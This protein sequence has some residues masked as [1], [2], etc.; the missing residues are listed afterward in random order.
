M[1]LRPLRMVIAALVALALLATG[2]AS[3]DTTSSSGGTGAGSGTET[4]I[5]AGWVNATELEP[6]TGG[7]LEVTLP[8]RPGGLDPNTSTLGLV[9]QGPI[10]TAI[11]DSLMRYDAETGTFTGQ[12]AEGLTSNDELTEWTLKLRPDVTFSD[13]T[14]FNAAA[15]VASMERLKTAR[16]LAATYPSFFSSIEA[17]DDL[18]VVLRLD[19]PLNNV[20]ALLATEMGFIVSP[21][22]VAAAGE[23]FSRSPVGAGPF[24]V[25]RFDPAAEL[26]LV[27]N[28]AYSLGEV[29]LDRIR[30]TWSNDQGANVDK[31][32]VG[33]A[34]MAFVGAVPQV[35]RA[36]SEGLPT[37]TTLVGGNG[38]AINNAAGKA[39]PG[40]D[41]RVRKAISMAIDPQVSNERAFD[42]DGVMGRWMMPPGNR[43]HVDTP[44]SVGDQDEAR[45]LVDAVKAETGWDG[46]AR[47][48]AQPSDQDMALSYQAQLNAIGFDAQLDPVQDASQM[49][50]RVTANR[51]FD[52]SIWI[53]TMYDTNIWQALS[54]S[55]SSTSTANYSGFSSP[56]MDALLDEL[57]G[58]P[59]DE[60]TRGV[61]DEIAEL[62]QAEQ[63]FFFAGT[64]TFST[65][66][67]DRVGG[68]VPT[69]QGV[70]LWSDVFKA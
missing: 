25:E 41:P 54:R 9:T 18:T 36:I 62:W 44:F 45:R 66:T 15:V 21:T 29:R 48:I 1:T 59:D 7:T 27:K 50:E 47:I 60:A 65:V 10:L 11:F 55:L 42:G 58:A 23:G 52:L 31:V 4:P 3:D 38:M 22:A 2:C 64:Q 5:R 13:G 28:P 61:L 57:R 30:M 8:A 46:K 6:S 14:P 56:E 26:V 33:Q 70:F 69:A 37:Y 43:F 17:T 19:T 12:L 49:V 39:F 67:T 53:M 63:P 34:D 51:D 20:D 68:L 32:L 40:N 16:G 24:M 35:A